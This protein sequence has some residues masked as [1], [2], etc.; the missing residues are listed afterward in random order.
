ME[1]FDSNLGLR[2]SFDKTSGTYYPVDSWDSRTEYKTAEPGESREGFCAISLLPNLGQTGSV[3][4][5]AG[6]GGSA[7]NAGA[8]FLA[9]E[10]SMAALQKRLARVSG[11]Q[12]FPY[13]E[14]LLRVKGRGSLPRD[15]KIEICREPRH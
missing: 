7:I 9:D 10:E 8:D 1:P 3:L 6:S 4:I 5:I 14:L 15:A 2:W 11:Q 12:Q 13:F